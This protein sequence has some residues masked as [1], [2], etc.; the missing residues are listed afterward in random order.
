MSQYLSHTAIYL[1]TLTAVVA[2]MNA[3][4]LTDAISRALAFILPF[5][6]IVLIETAKRMDQMEK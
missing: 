5:G 4:D 6:P 1:A 2:E 3:S